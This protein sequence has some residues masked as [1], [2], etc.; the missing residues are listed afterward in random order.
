MRRN[1]PQII[2]DDIVQS[3][4]SA[5]NTYNNASERRGLSV[6]RGRVGRRETNAIQ[7]LVSRQVSQD[8][9][10]VS[11]LL[12]ATG[13]CLSVREACH[14]YFYLIDRSIASRAFCSCSCWKKY[15]RAFFHLSFLGLD[16][17]DGLGRAVAS[18]SPIRPSVDR[19]KCS[20]GAPPCV[21]LS[22]ELSD[23][24]CFISSRASTLGWGGVL[25]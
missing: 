8:V 23:D 22:P 20:A 4:C 16:L 10:L 11:L 1:K 3:A 5:S 24:P 9:S 21:P 7:R 6:A 12:G 2:F 13:V 15:L 19:S 17:A 25:L 14:R 18:F